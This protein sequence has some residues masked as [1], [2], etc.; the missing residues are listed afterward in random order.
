MREED[1]GR[2]YDLLAR[3]GPASP[4][5]DLGRQPLP[6]RGIYF[7]FE[8]GEYRDDG[9]TP[10]VVRVGTHALRDGAV[11]T[12]QGRLAQHK[13]SL[14]GG[15]HRGSIFRLLIGE[16][17]AHQTPALAIATWG[18]GSSAPPQVRALETRLEQVVSGYLARTR[19]VVLPVLDDAGPNSLRG[20]IERNSIAL[21]S[22]SN[23]PA[24]DAASRTW[25]GRHSS[26]PAVTSSGLWNVR[27]TG[28]AYESGFLDIF[29]RLILGKGSLPNGPTHKGQAAKIP[30][31]SEQVVQ[32]TGHQ[33]Q[34]FGKMGPMFPMAIQVKLPELRDTVVQAQLLLPDQRPYFEGRLNITKGMFINTL[35]QASRSFGEWSRLWGREGEFYRGSVNE[36][37]RIW[38]RVKDG[39]YLLR[40]RSVTTSEALGAASPA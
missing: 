9:K 1:L 20:V 35:G 29:E 6:I 27:H 11:S 15:N 17:L 13:G 19:F 18:Q 38:Y 30:E 24:I 4:L 31:T 33:W 12:L 7:F 26:R 3:L 22:N 32:R 37:N 28:E 36:E 14:N 25:L 5:S 2:L 8:E 34:Y 16:A 10:R 39:A 21:L 40:F 23:K